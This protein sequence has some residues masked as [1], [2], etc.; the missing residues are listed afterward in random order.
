MR[1]KFEDISEGTVTTGR[2][3]GAEFYVTR[4]KR[5]IALDP[6]A[7]Y[8]YLK[9]KDEA[10]IAARIIQSD[11]NDID[12]LIALGKWCLYRNSYELAYQFLTRAKETGLDPATKI[13]KISASRQ[14]EVP[15]VLLMAESSWCAGHRA[16]ALQHFKT[17]SQQGA[18]TPYFSALQESSLSNQN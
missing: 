14:K 4:G 9:L 6:D 1:W 2:A 17:A 18:V 10:L 12:A 8:D 13:Q 7:P 11:P 16:E 3:G 5:L 15:F